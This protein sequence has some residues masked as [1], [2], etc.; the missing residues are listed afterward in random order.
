MNAI[1]E[2]IQIYKRIDEKSPEQLIATITTDV[3]WRSVGGKPQT[4]PHALRPI[5][6]N[7]GDE[8]L[9]PIIGIKMYV[10]AAEIRMIGLDR[11]RMLRDYCMLA[12]SACEMEQARLRYQKAEQLAA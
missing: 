10:G 12:C 9:C 1:T 3:L 7:L 11:R 2:E 6:R 5:L 4:R 8:L